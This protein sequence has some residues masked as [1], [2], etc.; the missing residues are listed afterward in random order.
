MTGRSTLLSVAA[1]VA[2]SCCAG[3][4][5]ANW[6]PFPDGV[7]LSS[8]PA[9]SQVRTASDGH[10]GMYVGWRDAAGP[11]W[12]QHLDFGGNPLWSP[13]G[14]KVSDT[15]YPST[16][17]GYMQID[18]SPDDVGGVYVT[19]EDYYNDV[20]GGHGTRTW[21]TRLDASG[22]VMPGFPVQLNI[23]GA[24]NNGSA[25]HP[26]VASDGAGNAVVAWADARNSGSPGCSAGTYQML[27][28]KVDATGHKLWINGGAPVS[29]PRDLT[30]YDLDSY[31]G[32]EP[33]MKPAPSAGGAYFVW[34]GFTSSCDQ[35]EVRI[36]RLD[37]FGLPHFGSNGLTLYS[38]E[39]PSAQAIATG[40]D[41]LVTIIN[42]WYPE[43]TALVKKVAAN[44]DTLWTQTLGS[45][46]GGF[47]ANA[48]PDGL[49]GVLYTW[50]PGHASPTAAVVQDIDANG[51]LL[52]PICSASARGTL[53]P[54]V[55]THDD[56]PPPC[57]VSDGKGGALVAMTSIGANP[58]LN[59]V[60]VQGVSQT[61]LLAFQTAGVL[62]GS[63]GQ[64]ANE[65][66][67]VP[68][69]L[70]NGLFAW[71]N[72]SGV[73]AQEVSLS[74]LDATTTPPGWA[75][76]LVP[77]SANNATTSLVGAAEM[78]EGEQTYLN[79][80]VTQRGPNP[81]PAFQMR[82][83]FDGAYYWALNVPDGAGPGYYASLNVGPT[84]PIPGGPH[85]LAL[86]TDWQSTLYSSIDEGSEADDVWSR[87]W[88]WEPTWV[89]V[90]HLLDPFPGL[91]GLFPMPNGNSHKFRV[92]TVPSPGPANAWVVSVAA[93][94]GPTFDHATGGLVGYG[95]SDGLLLYDVPA[96]VPEFTHLVGASHQPYNGTNFV[97]G[98]GTANPES[99]YTLAVRDS[100]QDAS[101]DSSW[102]DLQQ[103]DA[104]S[105]PVGTIWMGQGMAAGKL[106]DVYV[107][108]A[109]VRQSMR[110]T[111]H[112]R[113]VG[114]AS[115]GR[116]AF[117]LFAPNG[118]PA[119]QRGAGFGSFTRS[120]ELETLTVVATK[121]GPYLAVVFRADGSSAGTPLAYDFMTSATT[122]L[123]APN[124]ERPLAL[125]LRG[126]TPN[127]ASAT[128]L[129]I[130]FEL[131]TEAPARLELLDVSG[132]RVAF[133]DVGALGA[134]RHVVDLAQGGRIAPGLYLVRLTQGAN[135][136]TARA[137]VLGE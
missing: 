50:F 24:D 28:Q 115:T 107:L 7:Q 39:L 47:F 76:P 61:G 105:G 27:A 14:I 35:A 15:S 111:L 120:A 74:D 68:G 29:L 57:V 58:S 132:R 23:A 13:P 54:G 55:F 91:M 3:S 104:R 12:V 96:G 116:L 89:T 48:A 73:F 46:I 123:D 133:Q 5:H 44:G 66:S 118:V 86:Y 84:F 36:Q 75:G 33:Q 1:S 25:V 108:N 11:D 67:G 134:G 112:K 80:V 42:Y 69:F 106:A 65:L 81:T 124:A 19:Y 70:N 135:S 10:G 95:D 38:G 131:P 51:N 37:A 128:R 21:L 20:F 78:V 90:G 53:C 99:L 34:L 113:D 26:A 110:L 114:Q 8:A 2:L 16:W 63:P 22:S 64:S 117:E 59:Q 4:A 30:P 31:L 82:V 40:S 136:R 6:T 103:A 87:Q 109:I 62:A 72:S 32:G 71:G 122:T 94:R 18:V 79:W 83:Y 121:T 85:T 119:M 88:V 9:Y 92:P 52:L 101:P 98:P 100:A 125:A 130:D 137:A 127:P 56:A 45:D 102:F 49:G 41:C 43:Q 126:A 129:A 60:H 93:R 77:R 97:V 17:S